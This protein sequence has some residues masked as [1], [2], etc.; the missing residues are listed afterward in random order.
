MRVFTCVAEGLTIKSTL[1]RVRP[2]DSPTIEIDLAGNRGRASKVI[3]KK[4]RTAKGPDRVIRKGWCKC[5]SVREVVDGTVSGLTM[6]RLSM[7]SV[8]AV[9]LVACAGG[10]SG[11]TSIPTG[12]TTEPSFVTSTTQSSASSSTGSTTTADV[13]YVAF[14]DSWPEGAHCNGCTPF[15]ALWAEELESQFGQDIEFTDLTG[16]AEPSPDESKGSA[17]LLA[18]LKTHEETRDLVRN[19]DIILV[20]TGPNDMGSAIEEVRQGTCGGTEGFD[21]LRLLGEEWH[22]NFDA[23]LTEIH[24]L[25]EGAPTAIRLVNA[26]NP[27]L[28]YPEDNEGL[29]EDFPSTGGALI[30]DLLSAAMCDTAAN[31]GAV[32]VDARPILNGPN[33]DQ[34]ADEDSQDSMQAVADALIASGLGELSR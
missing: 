4:S 2:C 8:L 34:P 11:D 27:F 15:P 16:D 28:N 14:G 6:R 26:T 19:A 29:P 18:T 7:T 10:E 1:V 24:A 20:S 5:A 21:C 22:V 9:V 31:H 33:I 17:S 32:C 13:S 25:R 30:F 12:A 23:I 3:A